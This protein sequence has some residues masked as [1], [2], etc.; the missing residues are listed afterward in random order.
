MIRGLDIIRLEVTSSKTKN[1]WL[2]FSISASSNGTKLRGE[3]REREENI[4]ERDMQQT[5]S[6]KKAKTS[7]AG[8]VKRRMSKSA[9]TF[10]FLSP[11]R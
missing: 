11:L 1:E 7:P 10:W 5:H 9:F 8:K 4:A 3:E 2:S 6:K